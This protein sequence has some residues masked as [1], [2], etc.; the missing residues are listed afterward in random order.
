[1]DKQEQVKQLK[2]A[3]RTILKIVDPDYKPVAEKKKKVKR[4]EEESA[5]EKKAPPKKA[6]KEREG[7]FV[8]PGRLWDG[9][10]CESPDCTE[11]K[12]IKH[13]GHRTEVCK[14]CYRAREN[15]KD[16]LKKQSK[17]LL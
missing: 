1:M 9:K 7:P 11:I 12:G 4:E 8:C 5:P 2:V 3:F 14:V 15:A 16:K 13:D 10:P 6:K 17:S